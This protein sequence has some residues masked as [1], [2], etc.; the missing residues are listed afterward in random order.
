MAQLGKKLMSWIQTAFF[1]NRKG[2]IISA[3]PP[4]LL[5]APQLTSCVIPE[6]PQGVA[7]LGDHWAAAGREVG[8]LLLH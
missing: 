2:D 8:K 3:N 5:Q 7:F 1:T 6:G 4:F